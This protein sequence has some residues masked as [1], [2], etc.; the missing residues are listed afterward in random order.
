MS[1]FFFIFALIP[2][3]AYTMPAHYRDRGYMY[4]LDTIHMG[5]HI[6][7]TQ[8]KVFIIAGWCIHIMN[9]TVFHYNT[10]I[11]KLVMCHSSPLGDI[12]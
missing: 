7:K 6:S 3:S 11:Q 2:H 9:Q 4:L 8:V 5:W 1:V 10:C 12:R